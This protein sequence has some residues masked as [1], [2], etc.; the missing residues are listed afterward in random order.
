MGAGVGSLIGGK[1]K[2]Q[3]LIRT[4]LTCVL[5]DP[6]H[7]PVNAAGRPPTVVEWAA[8][9]NLPPDHFVRGLRTMHR[10]SQV[11]LLID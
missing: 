2:G 6:T 1:G 3:V 11:G 5:D 8:A 4:D 7:A 9:F 10:A